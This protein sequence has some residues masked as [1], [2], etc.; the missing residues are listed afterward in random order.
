MRDEPRTPPRPSLQARPEIEATVSR[1]NEGSN[2][3]KLKAT[4]SGGCPPLGFDIGQDSTTG[5]QRRVPVIW[6]HY[7]PSGG[8]RAL[9]GSEHSLE[10]KESGK[11][12]FRA[13][14][15]DAYGS[16]AEKW[17]DVTLQD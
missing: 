1:S 9:S 3:V 5:L 2:Q 8:Y 16:I 6:E 11:H 17:V 10:L 14:T 12:R 7:S 4:A 13:V 15:V